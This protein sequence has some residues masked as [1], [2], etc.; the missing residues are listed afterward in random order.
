[1]TLW[2]TFSLQRK[3]SQSHAILCSLLLHANINPQERRHYYNKNTVTEQHC[4]SCA[5]IFNINSYS[6]IGRFSN[7]GNK[8]GWHQLRHRLHDLASTG[9]MILW[10]KLVSDALFLLALFQLI[11]AW[12]QKYV[13]FHLLRV[14]TFMTLNRH[15]KAKI[16]PIYIQGSTSRR[17]FA[18]FFNTYRQLEFT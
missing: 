9:R 4:I 17:N 14:K 1:M 7:F 5:T 2:L 10:D 18:N 11:K 16:I 3:L 12:P 6:D 15:K 8:F 13:R